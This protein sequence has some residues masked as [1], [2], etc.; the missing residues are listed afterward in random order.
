ME[1]FRKPADG[2]Y[3]MLL[4]ITNPPKRIKPLPKI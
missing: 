3:G 2:G 1:R 4:C